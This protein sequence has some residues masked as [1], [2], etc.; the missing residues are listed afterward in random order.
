MKIKKK[1]DVS[2]L[3][4]KNINES[5]SS[6][7]ES[8]LTRVPSALSVDDKK[9][10]DSVSKASNSAPSPLEESKKIKT[11]K[12]ESSKNA[13]KDQELVESKSESKPDIK[14]DE[15][16]SN[17]QKDEISFAAQDAKNDKTV[18]LES[19]K[20]QDIDSTHISGARAKPQENSASL[21]KQAEI[22][23]IAQDKI[24]SLESENDSL[25]AELERTT[26]EAKGLRE[27]N[28]NLIKQVSALELR[29]KNTTEEFLNENQ[30]LREQLNKKEKE[31]IEVKLKLDEHDKRIEGDFN[32]IRVRER[33]LQNRLEIVKVE[34][35]AVVKSKDQMILDLKRQYQSLN[36]ELESL[37]KGHQNVQIKLDDEQ[38]RVKR[39]AKAVRVALSLLSGDENDILPIKKV[40]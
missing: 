30:N 37:K 32:K 27:I 19:H 40:D 26:S 2:E 13:A 25:R 28:E 5:E 20:A 29:G 31:L 23:K 7:D 39:A 35:Q 36:D 1:S 11:K 24:V 10:Q 33:E 16:T 15:S 18:H 14:L 6:H 9:V 38:E 12:E 22:I 8:G 21:L 3:L 34:H 17:K 4:E